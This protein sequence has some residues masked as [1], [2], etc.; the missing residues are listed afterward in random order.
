[1]GS[2]NG[3]CIISCVEMIYF[4]GLGLVHTMKKVL[5]LKLWEKEDTEEVEYEV[6]LVF[7]C[8]QYITVHHEI[9]NNS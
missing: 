9:D 3:F 5:G 1:M 4:L 2:F 8:T 7:T 6:S